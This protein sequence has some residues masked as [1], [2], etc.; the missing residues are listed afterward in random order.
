VGVTGGWLRGGRDGW[1]D[2]GS[3]GWGKRG[4]M[5]AGFFA[6]DMSV[7]WRVR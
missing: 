2:C 4:G 6:V 3:A 7:V 5:D 1:S